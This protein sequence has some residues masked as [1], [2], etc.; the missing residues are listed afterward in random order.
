MSAIIAQYP[1]AGVAY[2]PESLVADWRASGAWLWSTFGDELR[3]AAGEIP[4]KA[5]VISEDG[6]SSFSELD[7]ASESLAAGLLEMGLRPGDRALFQIGTIREIVTALFGCFKAGVIP[8]CTLPQYREH[9]IGQ[10]ARQSGAKAYF[11]QADF[12]PAFDLRGFAARMCLEHGIERL[13][14]VRGEARP[15]EHA[16]SDLTQRFEP[17]EA[18]RRTCNVKP[19]PGDVAMFQLSGG[20]T[21][22][23][24]IIPRMHG[25]YL[26][27]SAAWNR[28]HELT[29]E[30]VSLWALPLIHNAGM[31]V[32]LMPSLLARRTLVIMARF[33]TDAFLRAIERHRVTYTG[34]IGP[35]APSIIECPDIESYDLGSLRLFFTLA[36][37]EAVERKTGVPT[38]LMY[39][40]TE[41]LLMASEPTASVGQRQQTLGLPVGL[42]DQ[43]RLLEPGR[44]DPVALGEAGE[45]CFRSA[46]MLRAY[47]DAPE[48]SRESFTSDGFFRTG[49]LLRARV[50]DGRVCY[51][52]EGRLRDNINRGG[53]KFA[54]EEV[55]RFI[56]EHP[57]VNDVR[58]VAMPDRLLGEKA[59]AC[60]IPKPGAEVPDIASLGQ[61]LLS[62]GLAKYKLPE[63]VEAVPEFPVTR[64]GKVD[65]AALR[66][67]VTSASVHERGSE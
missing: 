31:I 40:I 22:V 30:D 18:R 13:V 45:L 5:F 44:E 34:S 48:I 67:L 25:E 64:V 33:E 27:S 47:H 53:E 26:G 16:F 9:E 37:A 2:H 56:A 28:R 61:F 12:S 55:E 17:A 21:G 19:L 42:D 36:R 4:D 66:A 35:I 11:V 24:K 10:L 57:A 54:A 38:Q 63:R 6:V 49:D 60:I 62:K 7:A 20:S 32:M 46:H 50:V 65:K 29:S 58:V 43:V 15:G 41:G 3:A 51:Q 8:V 52:F 59:C 39:G 23:P 1:L 14:V